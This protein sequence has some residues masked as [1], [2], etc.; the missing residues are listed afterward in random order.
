MTVHAVMLD[1]TPAL[2][3]TLAIATAPILWVNDL[4]LDGP[5]NEWVLIARLEAM[6]SAGT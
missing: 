6:E 5:V 2:V 1:Q 3:Q 4:R